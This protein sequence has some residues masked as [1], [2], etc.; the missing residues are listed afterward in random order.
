MIFRF[1]EK[2]INLS[3]SL[4]TMVV[5]NKKLL[6]AIVL[7]CF[8]F[9][10]LYIGIGNVFDSSL[11]HGEPY[12]YMASDAIWHELYSEVIKESGAFRYYPDYMAAGFDNVVA[13]NEPLLSHV[14][15]EFSYATGL[16]LYDAEMLLVFIIA[17]VSAFVFFLIIRKIDS[18]LAILSIPLSLLLF[19]DK[20]LTVYTWGIWTYLISTMFLISLAWAFAS[21]DLKKSYLLLGLFI[22][23]TIVG[24]FSN[25]LYALVFIGAYFALSL[26]TKK[27]RLKELKETVKA[28]ILAV[29]ISSYFLYVFYF[30]LAKAHAE[31]V[32]VISAADFTGYRVPLLV[33]LGWVGIIMA[34]GFIGYLIFVKKKLHPAYLLPIIMFILSFANYIGFGKRAFTIRYFWPIYLSVFFGLVFFLL[35]KAIKV[36]QKAVL[37][38][39][40]SFALIGFFGFHNY[41]NMTGS[42]MDPYHW[43]A[44][45]WIQKNIPQGD[46]MLYWYSYALDQTAVLIH[47]KRVPYFIKINRIAP[48]IEAGTIPQN[49]SLKLVNEGVAF[50]PYRKSVFS[51]GY[52]EKE[53]PSEFFAPVRSI[54]SF[55]YVLIDKVQRDPT[56]QAYNLM[57]IDKLISYGNQPVFNNPFSVILKLKGGDCLEE[58]NN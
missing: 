53:L 22:A 20:N 36:P 13:N 48:Y 40:I 4:E 34:L 19:Q 16:N 18:T 9:V 10:A 21:L 54:C 49:I 57:V 37:A 42:I 50:L 11:Q 41:Y 58:Q 23:G 32:E 12:G 56:I 44:F 29:I 5:F 3:R 28:G 52:Y 14:A 55:D 31:L 51:W 6:E 27:I 17:I 39:F 45:N 46:E 2:Y 7:L 47:G 8:F 26:F 38:T 33:E 35:L 43:E 25:F 30:T 1:I 24:Y 15:V